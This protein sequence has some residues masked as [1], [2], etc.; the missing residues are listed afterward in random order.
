MKHDP[1]DSLIY[2]TR[3]GLL[4]WAMDVLGDIPE[5]NRADEIDDVIEGLVSFKQSVAT[6]ARMHHDGR[7]KYSTGIPF[8]RVEAYLTTEPGDDGEPVPVIAEAHVTI[9]P[10]GYPFKPL[11]PG[12]IWLTNDNDDL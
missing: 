6:E 4:D 12:G 11:S 10:K 9:H 7:R 5:D 3:D 1:I 2:L 8:Q